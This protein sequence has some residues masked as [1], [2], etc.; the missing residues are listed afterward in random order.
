MRRINCNQLQTYRV[1]TQTDRGCPQPQRVEITTVLRCSRIALD[2]DAL[3]LHV[4]TLAA[5]RLTALDDG[6][7]ALAQYAARVRAL[8]PAEGIDELLRQEA[9]ALATPND[10]RP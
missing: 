2:S 3:P 10:V 7:P 1:A 4:Q 9:L 5:Q 8:P 6:S